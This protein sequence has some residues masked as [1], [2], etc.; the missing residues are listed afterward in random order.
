MTL[1]DRHVERFNEGVRTGDFSA[2][3]EA[4]AQGAEM[5]FEGIPV[6]PFQGRDAIAAA[7][8]AQPPDDELVVLDQREDDGELVATYAWAA[9]PEL[10]AGELRLAVQHGAIS[11]VIIRYGLVG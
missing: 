7:Y 2:M 6:G 8:R 10:P 11:R 9:E 1:P 3:V 5:R 4:L